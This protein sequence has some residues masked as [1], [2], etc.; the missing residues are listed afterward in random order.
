MNN[1]AAIGLFNAA[2]IAIPLWGVLWFGAVIGFG[3]LF[4]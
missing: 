1:D 4:Q 3:V 2:I